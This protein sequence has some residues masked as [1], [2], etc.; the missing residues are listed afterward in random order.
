MR[1]YRK[2]NQTE[3]WGI[4]GIPEAQLETWSHQGA[5][6]T[7]RDTYSAIANALQDSSAG[8]A[9]KDFDIY[10]QGSYGNDTNIYAE[11]DVDIV[12]QLN[13]T[14]FSNKDELPLEQFALHEAD[15]GPAEYKLDEFR[16]DVISVLRGH[17]GVGSVEDGRRSVK[18]HQSGGRRKAD[19]VVCALYKNYSYYYGRNNCTFKSG[20][21]IVN[22]GEAVVNY[23]KLHSDALTHKHQITCCRYK[24]L[25]RVLKNMK[26]TLV[27]CGA[28]DEK[29]APSYFIEGW[30]YN[31]PESLYVNGQQ[32]RFVKVVNWLL[33]QDKDQFYMPHGMY[34]LIGDSL[35]Q[36]APAKYS[37][38]T[39]AL[40]E[41]WNN[42]R[43]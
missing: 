23:P 18:V 7:S 34:P 41:L 26:S 27:D 12:I 3:I 30:L 9:N 38:F 35:T 1:G 6:A 20:I 25:V 21:K 43:R 10:L 42:W 11:S 19:V 31:A 33:E 29:T 17:F 40:I 32:D 4:M 22:A 8:Y 15:F 39:K 2:L 16:Q 24:P 5:I 28:I 13:S 36:W 14:F 37:T